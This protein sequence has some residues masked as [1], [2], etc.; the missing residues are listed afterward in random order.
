MNHIIQ[1]SVNSYAAKG[2]HQLRGLPS[3]ELRQ[4]SE[5][6]SRITFACA[7]NLSTALKV[8]VNWVEV[9]RTVADIREVRFRNIWKSWNSSNLKIKLFGE[10]LHFILGSF[11]WQHQICIKL[12]YGTLGSCLYLKRNEGK[13]YV[14]N[15]ATKF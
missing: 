2:V 4:P 8:G 3:V 11:V 10:F 7:G 5:E 12:K 15:V 1:H 6:N 13:L 9:V 14:N